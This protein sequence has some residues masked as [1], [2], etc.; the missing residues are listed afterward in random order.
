MARNRRQEGLESL[1][2]GRAKEHWAAGTFTEWLWTTARPE[3]DIGADLVV[4]IPA[5]RD[6]VG[7]S[8]VV[9]SRSHKRRVR[10]ETIERASALRLQGSVLPVFVLSIHHGS[11]RVRWM[12]IEPLFDTEPTYLGGGDLKVR[13]VDSQAFSLTDSAPPADFVAA[14]HRAR[15]RGGLKAT[16]SMRLHALATEEKYRE[17][18]PDFVVHPSYDDGKEVLTIGARDVPVTFQLQ[19]ELRTSQHKKSVRDA[20]EWGSTAHVPDST[21][22]ISGSPLFEHIF[23]SKAITE[24]MLM[25]EALWEGSGIL[26]YQDAAN[27]SRTEVVDARISTG[28][29]GVQL[30]ATFFNGLLT[31][32]F[33]MDSAKTGSARLDITYGLVRGR[34][35]DELKRVAHALRLLEA[36]AV[37]RSFLLAVEPPQSHEPLQFSWSANVTQELEAA[38]LIFQSAAALLRMARQQEWELSDFPMLDISPVQMQTVIAAE[39]LLRGEHVKL[40]PIRFSFKCPTRP[41]LDEARSSRITIVHGNELPVYVGS[42]LLGALPA[43]VMLRNYG[44]ALEQIVGSGEWMVSCTPTE[45]STREYFPPD[46]DMP[47]P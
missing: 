28:T 20:F 37:G 14:I 33:R 42:A 22:S 25:P 21:F 32:T 29:K 43:W 16:P 4:E 5:H 24:M 8:F 23:K 30:T 31:F 36:A 6:A 2:R 15:A 17:I 26:C 9:Q 7:A 41:G 45:D 19:M 40:P 12:Y 34:K 38:L 3:P 46:Q 11:G 13:M 44:W 39:A 18:D 27:H 35:V 10:T 47:K 1:F